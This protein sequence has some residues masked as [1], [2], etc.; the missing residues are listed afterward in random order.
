M[1]ITDI[2]DDRDMAPYDL[3]LGDFLELWIDGHAFQNQDL[4]ALAPGAADDTELLMDIGRPQTPDRAFMAVYILNPS[5]CYACDIVTSTNIITAYS[6][7]IKKY[8][9]K[10]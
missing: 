1:V 4:G 5:M 2:G 8:C 3:L 7:K 10:I 6:Q 9:T